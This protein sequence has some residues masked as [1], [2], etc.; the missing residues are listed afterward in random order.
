M[1]NFNNELSACEYSLKRNYLQRALAFSISSL[2]LSVENLTAY[3]DEFKGSNSNEER[4]RFTSWTNHYQSSKIHV[5]FY[6]VEIAN[7]L[8][9]TSGE[10]E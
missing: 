9:L 2:E 7:A 1:D 10:D 6:I 4:A 8:A 3:L 5:N